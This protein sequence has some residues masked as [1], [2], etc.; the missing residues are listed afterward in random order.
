MKSE[1]LQS[2]DSSR[3]IAY[4]RPAINAPSGSRSGDP[5]SGMSRGA[6]QRGSVWALSGTRFG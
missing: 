2:R 3:R 1:W 4:W 6:R 5:S